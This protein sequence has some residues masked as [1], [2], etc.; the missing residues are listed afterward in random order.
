MSCDP[1]MMIMDQIV[2]STIKNVS[3]GSSNRLLPGFSVGLLSWRLFGVFFSFVIR[4]V[5]DTAARKLNQGRK[6][7]KQKKKKTKK[8]DSPSSKYEHRRTSA[9]LRN[10]RNTSQLPLR[11]TPLGPAV[12]VSLRE[13]SVL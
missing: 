13:M 10:I 2:A 9:L 1:L 6:K 3:P 7:K 5:R 4:K 8:N 11:R 12:S